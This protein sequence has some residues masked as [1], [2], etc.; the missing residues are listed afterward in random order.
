[1]F[2]ALLKV[3]VIWLLFSLLTVGHGPS[4][5]TTPDLTPGHSRYAVCEGLPSATISDCETMSSAWKQH[6]P[7]TVR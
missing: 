2:K 4:T 6:D 7:G 3:G 1:M 5:P